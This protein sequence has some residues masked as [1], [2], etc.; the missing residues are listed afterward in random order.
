MIGR[1]LRQHQ[2]EKVAQRKRI[3]GTPRNRA[4]GIQAFEIADQEQPKVPPRRQSWAPLVR[5][6]A[7]AEALDVFI[8]VMLVKNVIQS[9]VERMRSTPQQIV[10]RH[11]H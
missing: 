11:P 8:E 1:R 7:L 5:I 10:R 2:P 6:E 4:L 3:G 9:R